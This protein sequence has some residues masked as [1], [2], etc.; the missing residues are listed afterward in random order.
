MSELIDV[1]FKLAVVI[2]LIYGL[3]WVLRRTSVAR[4]G[5]APRSERS[6]EL[7]E[8]LALGQQRSIHL[9]RVGGRVLAVG[10]TPS[11]VSVLTEIDALPRPLPSDP[12]FVGGT[13]VPG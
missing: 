1:A 5:W 11:Q 4:L 8:T 6:L 9:V 7:V 10:A 13:K 2:G 12:D 3:A